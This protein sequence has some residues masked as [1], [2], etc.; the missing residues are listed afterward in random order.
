MTSSHYLPKNRLTAVDAK[1][2][3]LDTK[4]LM[5]AKNPL[6]IISL[7]VF[8]WEI[9]M[10]GFG[11]M[12]HKLLNS[13]ELLEIYKGQQSTRR[14][15][16]FL[17]EPSFMTPAVAHPCEEEGNGGERAGYGSRKIP[18]GEGFRTSV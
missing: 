4:V 10:V 17:K 7:T 8:S 16:R 6:I 9:F 2:L 12:N 18:Y 15:F 14:R 1:N 11:E 13:K 3:S 5:Q